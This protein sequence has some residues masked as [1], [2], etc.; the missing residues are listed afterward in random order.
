MRQFYQNHIR[1]AQAI[2]LV[3][4]MA[5]TAFVGSV[6]PGQANVI[7]QTV[8]KIGPVAYVPTSNSDITRI[9]IQNPYDGKSL[10]EANSQL[11]ISRT[12]K[13]KEVTVKVPVAVSA[14][15]QPGGGMLAAK[16]GFVSL[17]TAGS[18][19]FMPGDKLVDY[20]D[21]Q[22]Q[23]CDQNERRAVAGRG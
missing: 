10:V 19:T 21:V 12:V 7:N 14:S 13:G 9:V 5:I 22:R 8:L 4:L 23:R 1:S 3:M 2:V 20:P 16:D 6:R 18:A 17:G 15:S 11:T